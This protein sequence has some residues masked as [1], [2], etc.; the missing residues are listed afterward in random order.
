[1]KHVLSLSAICLFASFCPAA[2]INLTVKAEANGTNAITVEPGAAVAFRVEGTLSGTASDGLALLGFDVD[3]TGGALA[4][5]TITPPSGTPSC[6][7]P[8]VNFVKLLGITNPAGYGGTLIAGDLIQVGGGQNTI[9]NVAENAAFPI[10][11][12]IP[13]V[14]IPGGCPSGGPAIVAAGSLNAP[15]A[16]GVYTLQVSNVFANVIRDG[17]SGEVFWATDPATLGTTTNL[18]ITVEAGGIIPAALT[19]ANPT[20]DTALSRASTSV[21]RLTFD[22][23]IPAPIAGDIAI[24]ELGPAG[25]FVGGDLSAQ[26]TFTRESG[27]TVLR[28]Q[29]TGSVLVNTKWYGITNASWDGVDPFKVTHISMPGNVNN[30]GFTDFSDLSA[31]FA[32]QTNSP[33]DNDP[34]NVNADGFVDFSDLSAAFSFNGAVRPAKPDGHDCP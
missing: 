20:C 18:T 24:R 13:Q 12:V 9:N 5:N 22:A 21:I 27:N 28:I 3:F 15:M 11:E 2:T 32:S 14:A 30:D 26:F 17:E 19:G 29:E 31:I 16:D 8:M 34:Y 6:A 1:M 33:A 7:N 4:A 10:G 25:T 23:A